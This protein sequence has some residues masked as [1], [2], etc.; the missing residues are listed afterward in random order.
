M[1][2]NYVPSEICDSYYQGFIEG[3]TLADE[4]MIEKA[5]KWLKTLTYQEFAGAPL[6]RLITD[7]LISEFRQTM[8]GE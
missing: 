1:V 2:A 4:T 3:T 8:K 7:E 6:E 5:C